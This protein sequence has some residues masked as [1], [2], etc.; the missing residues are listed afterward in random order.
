[1]IGR[2]EFA[3]AAQ[4]ERTNRMAMLLVFIGAA[5]V[6]LDA[7]VIEI[8][9]AQSG[10]VITYLLFVDPRGHFTPPRLPSPAGV[11]AACAA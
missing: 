2:I 6:L 11:I 10:L 9:A 7:S 4:R 5:G 1:M 8:V 3:S